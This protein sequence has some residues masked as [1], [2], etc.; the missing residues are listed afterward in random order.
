[1]TRTLLGTDLVDAFVP[2]AASFAEAVSL[3]VATGAPMV[4]VL[5]NERNVVGLFGGEQALRGVLPRYVAE[6]RHTAFAPDDAAL[7]AERAA[8]VQDEPVER[9]AVKP[10]TVAVDS[11][12]IHA[13]EV[14][15]H[16]RLPAVAV[17]EGGRFVGMLAR[18]AFVRS[19]AERLGRPLETA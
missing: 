12:A 5:D 14:F 4:A 16:C 17:V 19:L 1:M 6:L 11:S 2:R 18:D 13:G 8:E 9:H 10:V 3:L 15:L 7:L